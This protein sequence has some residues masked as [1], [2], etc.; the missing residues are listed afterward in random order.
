MAAQSTANVLSGFRLQ[1]DLLEFELAD[2]GKQISCS[3]SREALE[4]AGAGY[5]ARNWQLQEVFERL[6]KRITR[7]LLDKQGAAKANSRAALHISTADLNAAVMPA[8]ARA[9]RAARA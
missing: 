7:L 6:Q 8:S 1:D 3:I 4:E 5:R 2:A 9:G